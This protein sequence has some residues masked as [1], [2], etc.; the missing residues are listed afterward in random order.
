[1]CIYKHTYTSILISCMHLQRAGACAS[2]GI[3]G[4]IVGLTENPSLLERC[5][6]IFPETSHVVGEFSGDRDMSIDTSPSIT[7]KSRTSGAAN[8]STEINAASRPT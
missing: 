3:I 7:M 4:G 8:S 2:A 6:V 5:T 1:M